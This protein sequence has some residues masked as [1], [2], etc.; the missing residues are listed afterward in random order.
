L[1]A[2]S[3]LLRQVRSIFLCYRREDSLDATHRLYD[4]LTESFDAAAVLMDLDTIP[5]G[6]DFSR[7]LT[8]TLGGCQVVLAI[9][10]D[11][12]IGARDALGGRRLDDPTDFV[13]LEIRTALELNKPVIPVLVGR[14]AMP[15]EHALPVDIQPL[16]FR[17]AAELRSGPSY[18]EQLNRLIYVLKGIVHTEGAGRVSGDVGGSAD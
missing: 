12:W 13:R 6:A 18:K 5:P 9:I 16:A 10:G 17:Q 1:E 14:A 15:P 3:A 11:H 7:F 4:A 8:E 2:A